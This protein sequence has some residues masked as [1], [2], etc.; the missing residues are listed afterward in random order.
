MLEVISAQELAGAEHFL[1]VHGLIPATKVNP[2]TLEK[3][4]DKGRTSPREAVWVQET[5]NSLLLPA[6]ALEQYDADHGDRS[7][8][9]CYGN[10][11]A[12]RT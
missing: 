3:P 11:D 12:V 2:Q 1:S 5:S 4:I 6:P 9:N 7:F 10:V 8:G